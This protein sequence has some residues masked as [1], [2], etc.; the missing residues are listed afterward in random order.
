MASIINA[1]KAMAHQLGLR[2]VAEGIE[3]DEQLA[4]LRALDCEMGQG[5]LFSRPVDAT[6]AATLLTAGMPLR[7]PVALSALPAMP[8]RTVNALRTTAPS[9]WRGVATRRWL[10][11]AAGAVVVVLSVGLPRLVGTRPP[12]TPAN[13]APSPAGRADLNADIPLT[14]PAAEL[15]LA[16]PSPSRTAARRDPAP[17]TAAPP[18]APAAPMAVTSLRVVHQHRLGNCRGLLVVTRDGVDYQPD[19]AEH[20]AKDGF[21]F[22]Y[23]RFLSEMS[24][25]SLVIRSNNR[26]YRFKA[27]VAGNGDGHIERIDAAIARLR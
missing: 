26:D 3:K 17:A 23:T 22:E 12:E 11:A 16:T 21:T 19:E 5:F 9:G 15:P 8:M 25:D 2:V 10:Y 18:P 20:Q 7:E 13:E 6:G 27:D 1:V 14:P 4:L 24:G